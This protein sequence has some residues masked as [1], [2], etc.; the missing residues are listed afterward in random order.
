MKHLYVPLQ[1]HWSIRDTT[2]NNNR[3]P[4]NKSSK[5]PKS[6]NIVLTYLL[7]NIENGYFS[8]SSATLTSDHSDF[9]IF[10]HTANYGQLHCTNNLIFQMLMRMASVEVVTLIGNVDPIWNQTDWPWWAAM[11]S[12]QCMLVHRSIS[13]ACSYQTIIYDMPIDGPYFG[14]IDQR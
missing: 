2:P 11:G 9:A 3:I 8:D 1:F 10:S 12:I 4:K 6:Y 13:F 7:F 5:N 14:L